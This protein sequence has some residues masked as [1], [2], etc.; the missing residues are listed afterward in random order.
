VRRSFDRIGIQVTSAGTTGAVI[1][2]GVYASSGGVP[3]V[4]IVDAG[5]I[6]AD[7]I[8][9]KEATISTTLEPGLHW[10]AIAAQVAACSVVWYPSNVVT[11]FNPYRTT[12]QNASTHD[13]AK[14][15]ASIS[16]ALPSTAAASGTA[17]GA[18][19]P[20]LRAS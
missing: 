5:T 4:L 19:A 7:A 17:A 1:R 11:P 2:M 12:P 9:S 20:M 10:T 8:G 14:T 16:G 13:V 18:P 3:T 6:A 15:Q